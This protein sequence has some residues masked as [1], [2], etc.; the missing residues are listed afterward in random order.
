V[1]WLAVKGLKDQTSA[2]EEAIMV[3]CIRTGGHSRSG[4]RMR[5]RLK[6][7]FRRDLVSWTI[8]AG[9]LKSTCLFGFK[10]RTLACWV[11]IYS[12]RDNMNLKELVA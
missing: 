11:L 3:R 8:E 2:H 1:S 10:L 12:R 6:S 4:G 5:E 9:S 7:R